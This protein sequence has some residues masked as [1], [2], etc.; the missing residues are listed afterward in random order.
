MSREPW[1][2]LSAVA[3][4]DLR[5]ALRQV[6]WAVQLIAASGQTFAE[7]EVDDS[8]RAAV[9]DPELSSFVGRGFAGSY[10]FRVSLRPE[11]LTLVL[12][13]RTDAALGSLPLAGRTLDE[14]YEWLSL[15]LATYMGA[16]PPVLS[17][18][19]YDVPA[20]PVGEGASFAAGLD[21]ELRTI[22]ALYAASAALLEEVAAARPEASPVRCWPH[23]FD[24]ATLLTVTPAAGESPAHTVGVGMAPEG[25]GYD[26]WYWYVTPWPYPAP[27]RLPALEGPGAWHTEGWTGAVLSGDELTRA[28]AGDRRALVQGFVA[29]ASGAAERSLEDPPG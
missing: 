9:W 17:R 1:K 26:D 22:S 25:G 15:G 8:H 11:D 19:E 14:G 24:I 16:P 13:D 2:D 18:P 23:H 4:A 3:P 29:R 5:D 27:E 12:L 28:P 21:A 10:P 6:H 7:P 20:H